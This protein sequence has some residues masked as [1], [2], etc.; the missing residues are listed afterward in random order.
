[1][2]LDNQNS[3]IIID[4]KKLQKMNEIF[5]KVLKEITPDRQQVLDEIEVFL[6]RLR[7][8]L[9]KNDIL[10][11][12]CLGGSVAKNTNLTDSYDCD[13]FIR[14]DYQKYRDQDI[15]LILAEALKPFN[16]ELVH[17]SRD[18]F[19]LEDFID[20]EIVPVLKVDT[21]D[22][23]QN[24]TDMSP[25]HVKWVLKYPEMSD[26]IR[27]TKRFFQSQKIYGAESYIGG[28]SGHVLDIITIY[29]NGFLNLLKASQSWE[30]KEVIDPE[31]YFKGFALQELNKSKIESPLIVVDPVFPERNASAALSKEKFE[32]FIKSAKKFLNN[33]SAEFFEIEEL[34]P[35]LLFEKYGE[36]LI[37]FSLTPLEGKRDVVGAKMM[38]IFKMFNNQINFYDFEIVFSDWYWNKKDKALLWFATKKKKLLPLQK[39]IGPPLSDEEN[40]EIF[41]KKHEKTFI[42]DNRICVYIPRKYSELIKLMKDLKRDPEVLEKVKKIEL[43]DPKKVL[44]N[45]NSSKKTK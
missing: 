19:Q 14:F 8:V 5:E 9:K 2:E 26:E 25:F 36:E 13:I 35:K 29:Y 10:A 24:T 45:N 27:L 4:E 3:E 15:S 37:V 32:K 1:M 21:P 33:P 31:N 12:V 41:K 17:G 44:E 30:D 6:R 11:E 16:S 39:R 40:V 34:S 42:E 23:A 38:K 18:Y 28:F 43:I 20:Y 7:E 22:L